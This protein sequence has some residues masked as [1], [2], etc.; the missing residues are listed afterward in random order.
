MK[1]YFGNIEKET[2]G[3]DNFR[4]V[5]YTASRSQLVLMSLNPGEDIGEEVHKVDQFLRIEQGRG[6]AFLNEVSHEVEDG[7]AIVVPAGVT[8]NIKNTGDSKMKLYTIYS[9]PEHKKDT[10]HTTKEEALAD[11]EDHFNGETNE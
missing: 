7:S 1:G 6:K 8:H 4:K 2:I 5:V 11:I 9:P 3:N 10:I